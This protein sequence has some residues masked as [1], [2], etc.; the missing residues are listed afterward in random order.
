MKKEKTRFALWID[1]ETLK[2]V[3]EHYSSDGCRT[4]SEFIARAIR[5]YC[6]YL[7]A[8]KAGDYLP[9]TVASTLEGVLL[10]FGDRLGR[11]LFRLVVEVGMMGRI[12]AAD[13]AMDN[14]TIERLR[15]ECVRDAKK[16]NGQISFRDALRFCD[17]DM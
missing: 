13:T 4:Q 15:A 14:E 8:K 10:M 7:T 16:T 9:S 11:L 3:Q 12:I 2:Q 17:L 1:E 5:F 6:G